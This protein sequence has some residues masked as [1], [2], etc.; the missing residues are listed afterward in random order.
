MRVKLSPGCS[1]VQ[2][3][4]CQEELFSVGR[5]QEADSYMLVL[6]QASSHTLVS[7]NSRC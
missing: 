7:E 5:L 1:R 4:N 6:R 2:A 3:T